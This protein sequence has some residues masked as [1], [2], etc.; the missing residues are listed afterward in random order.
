[1]F[2]GLLGNVK[3][4]SLSVHLLSL[5]SKPCKLQKEILLKIKIYLGAQFKL[6]PAC[7]IDE[8]QS[9]KS[10]AFEPPD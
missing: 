10:S 2:I 6:L 4:K 1:M 9:N 3:Y 8:N 7:P 5:S